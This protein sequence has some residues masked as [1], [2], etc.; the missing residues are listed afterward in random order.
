MDYIVFRWRT[1]LVDLYGL[2]GVLVRKGV[3]CLWTIFYYF[4]GGQVICNLCTQVFFVFI[5][6]LSKVYRLF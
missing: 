3:F 1:H 6:Q 4:F 5:I 2:V